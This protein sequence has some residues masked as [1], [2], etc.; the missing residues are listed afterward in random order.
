MNSSYMRFQQSVQIVRVSNCS[1]EWMQVQFL[2]LLPAAKGLRIQIFS[3][4]PLVR[5]VP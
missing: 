2:N 1:I 4:R 3:D 5:V